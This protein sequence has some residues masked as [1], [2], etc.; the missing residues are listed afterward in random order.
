MKS[1]TAFI[2]KKRKG[3]FLPSLAVD[4]LFQLKANF[5]PNG[6]PFSNANF[7]TIGFRKPNFETSV[8]VHSTFAVETLCGEEVLAVVG[9][10]DFVVAHVISFLSHLTLLSIYEQAGF[11]WRESAL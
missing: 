7:I 3:G 4:C 11:V 5:L 8:N 9:N 10:A 6:L 1:W 2:Y